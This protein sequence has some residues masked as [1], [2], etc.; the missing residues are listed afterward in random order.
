ML[1]WERNIPG[2][3]TE[4]R[5][6]LGFILFTAG[7]ALVF[8]NLY[9]PFGVDKW[10]DVSDFQLFLYSSIVILIGMLVI[11]ISRMLMFLLTRK[12]PISYGE[13]AVWIIGEILC[14]SL[15]YALIQKFFLHV[16]NDFM[17]IIRNSVRIT[18]NII[19]LPYVFSWLYLAFRDK[20]MKLE[21]ISGYSPEVDIDG[22]AEKKSIGSLSMIPFADEKG[23]LKFSIKKED[24]LYLEAADNYVIIHYIDD[25][26]PA[27]YII[28]NT[29]RRI[30]NWQPNASLVRCHRSFMVNIDTVKVI[31]KEKE[32]LII[33]FESPVNTT[34]PISK[35]YLDGLI[36][37]LSLI[38]PDDE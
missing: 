3:L 1:L 20:Y 2:Y 7:F 6:V 27:R 23:I 10:L 13:Y 17:V 19:L 16:E 15:V 8:I 30:E 26:K 28:R 36:R 5:N 34:I 11:V 33:G 37:K 32:G 31:R 4:R 12:R 25:R 9:A 29:L 38:T 35:T 22:Q 18:A 14:M 21:K 24:L